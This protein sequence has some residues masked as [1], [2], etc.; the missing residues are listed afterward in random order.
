MDLMRAI[1]QRYSAGDMKTEP[2]SRMQLEKLLGAAVQA[3]NHHKV[4]PWRFIVLTGGGREKL[5]AVFAETLQERFPDC[6][7][8]ALEKE[9][10]KP[11][12]AP[13]IIAVAADA[14]ADPRVKMI[15]NICAAAAACENLLLAAEEMGLAT[16]W[17]T[18]D[19]AGDPHVKRFLGLSEDQELIAFLYIGYPE[20]AQQAPQRP[21]F[22]DRTV[23]IS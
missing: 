8:A 18:G 6:P 19:A 17:R 16:H 15:E 4:R 9:R 14:P 1:Y 20:G 22:E 7:P 11:L 21:S 5:G 10:A 12:R 3:P 13:V 23:W 2:V